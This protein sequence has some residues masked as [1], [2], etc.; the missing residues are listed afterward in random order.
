MSR[1]DSGL[2]RGLASQLWQSLPLLLALDA[3]LVIAAI[4]VLATARV[5][6]PAAPLVAALTVGPAWATATALTDQLTADRV[7]RLSDIASAF[8]EHA[9]TGVRVAAPA[10][11]LASA[12]LHVLAVTTLNSWGLLALALATAALVVIGVLTPAAYCM[13]VTAGRH[14]WMLWRTAASVAGMRPLFTVGS[15]ALLVATATGLSSLSPALALGIAAVLPAPLAMY[16]SALTWY[17][18]EER[19][20]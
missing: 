10:A 12:I 7:R 3:L 17:I 6:L 1:D 5:W 19:N 2:L 16:A 14:G 9:L 13:A 15:I 4:P 8:R 18:V 11:V 20:P